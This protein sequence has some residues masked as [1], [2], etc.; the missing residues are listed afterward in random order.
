MSWVAAWKMGSFLFVL[1]EYD[2]V[3]KIDFEALPDCQ[4]VRFLLR[5]ASNGSNGRNVLGRMCGV[6]CTLCSFI[7]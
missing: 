5:R 6:T 7:A 1:W 3:L 4:R 2:R